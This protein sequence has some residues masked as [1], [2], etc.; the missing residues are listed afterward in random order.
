MGK[1][2]LDSQIPFIRADGVKLDSKEE[3]ADR[4]AQRNEDLF[5]DG[6]PACDIAKAAHPK[7]CH[8]A[9]DAGHNQYRENPESQVSSGNDVVFR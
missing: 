4:S 1:I 8:P 3:N 2:I 6:G 7:E 9:T 5:P